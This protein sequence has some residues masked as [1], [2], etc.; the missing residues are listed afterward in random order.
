MKSAI[1]QP[2]SVTASK[3]PISVKS[4][5][6]YYLTEASGTIPSA[7]DSRWKLVNEG[8]AVPMPTSA[9]PY[10]WK[11][12]VTTFTDGTSSTAIE[13]GGSLGKNG[14]DYDLVPSHS[15]IVKAEDG[16][17]S[18]T[19]VSCKIIKRNADG[20]AEQLSSVPTG[21]SIAV[22]R[23]STAVSSAYTPG[24]N[25]S[26]SGTTTSI[27]FVLKY[28]SVEV[29]RHSLNVIAEG[30]QGIDG[31]GIQSQDYRF[32]ATASSAVPSSP[33]NDTTWNTWFT[34]SNSGY[35]AANPYLWR[36]CKTVYVDGNG[37]TET[38]YLVDG[39]TVWGQDGDDAVYLDLDNQ[40]D[41][42]SVNPSG[43]M[44]DH[45]TFTIHATLYKGASPVTGGI[46]APT[47]SAITLNGVTP[48]VNT[49]GGVVTIQYAFTSIPTIFEDR[50][51]TV[52]IPVV[53]GGKTY[54]A[55]FTLAPV[56]KGES[57]RTYNVIPS[58]SAC[59]FARNTDNSLSPASYS[60]TCGYSSSNGS[61]VATYANVTGTF[62]TSWHIFYRTKSNNAYGSWTSY[63]GAITITPSHQAIEF[64]IAKTTTAS[65]VVDSN[66]VDREVVPVLVGGSNGTNAFVVDLD[67]EM[68]AIPC[69][70]SGYLSS[71]RTFNLNIGAYYGTTSVNLNSVSGTVNSTNS[72][73]SINTNT[74]KSPVIT[75]AAGTYAGTYEFT[76]TC[77]HNTYGT[78]TVVFTVAV[79]KAGS[80][81]SSPTMYQ[82]VPSHTALSFAR[83]SNGNL[84]GS[85][86]VTCKIKKTVGASSEVKDS[87]SGLT[88]KW[89]WNSKDPCESAYSPLSLNAGS[90][91]NSNIV[92][93][94]YSGSTRIDRE[95]I[96]IIKDGS[97]GGTG[98]PGNGIASVSFARMFTMAFS[99]PSSSASGWIASTSSSY[100]SE[101]GLSKENRYLWQRKTTTY[102][103][104]SVAT[105]Y[106]VSLLAQYESGVCANLLE[107]TAF[108]DINDMDAWLDK[109]GGVALR[110]FENING[111][112]FA[113]ISNAAY[114][115]VLKQEVYLSTGVKKL[116]ANTWYTFSFYGA[117]YATHEI[118]NS[119]LYQSNNVSPYYQVQNVSGQLYLDANQSIT[120][121]VT[122]YVASSSVYMRYYIYRKNSNGT[123][124]QSAQCHFSSTT[125]STVRMTLTNNSGAAAQYYLGGYV[126]NS[127][128]SQN[129]SSATSHRGYINKVVCYRGCCIDTYLYNA[130]GGSAVVADSSAP[131]ICD[132]VACSGVKSLS[133]AGSYPQMNGTWVQFSGDGHVRWQMNPSTRRHSVTFKTVSTLNAGQSYRILFRATGYAHSGWICMPKLERN[134]MATEWIEH[135]NDRMAAD[136]QHIY[137]GEWSASTAYMYANGVR[138]VVRAP[139][140][141]GTKT[142]FRL[143]KRTPASGRVSSTSPYADTSWWEEA[144]F[145]RFAAAELLLADQAI[146]TFTQTNRILVKNSA[147]SV[148]AGMGGAVGDGDV[149][150]WVGASYENRLSAPFR[151]NIQG[152]IFGTK[153]MIGGWVLADTKMY[154]QLGRISGT[155]STDYTNSSFVPNISLDSVN[156]EILAGKDVRING[157]GIQ[158]FN[159]NTL[160]AK[161]SNEF[162][163]TAIDT[164]PQTGN[165]TLSANYANSV[166]IPTTAYYRSTATWQVTKDCGYCYNGSTI[167]LTNATF[168][169]TLPAAPSGGTLSW[170]TSTLKVYVKGSNGGSYVFY[171]TTVTSSTINQ[172]LTFS[173]TVTIDGTSLKEGRYTIYYEI[174]SQ[175]T[176]QFASGSTPSAT[177][178]VS[179]AGW[180]Y[181]RS[182][183][184]ITLIGNNGIFTRNSNTTY[185]IQTSGG[186]LAR[187]GN[188]A[189]RVTS[190]G[191]QKSVNGGT[192]WTSL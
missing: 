36:C 49:S 2:F 163:S 126:Y 101:S 99:A 175:F 172:T 30:G 100:P 179:A 131:W 79:Q 188:Y 32:K 64:C 3:E 62:N 167:K 77:K 176:S 122:G 128:G 104:T 63:S 117:M 174:V 53:Y 164:T 183:A 85:Y 105:T 92:F 13:F 48:T 84:T 187:C 72:G 61:S 125:V 43:A 14:I 95:T 138:H 123:W 44:T 135:T 181:S 80:P 168:K 82:L 25:V 113:P 41:S 115:D 136:F 17:L 69:D 106:E 142:F 38:T 51:Y 91:A 18:P 148:S 87:Y 98:D 137:A 10:L 31:R 9:A 78:R 12:T 150:L 20:T 96:P 154:S 93:E 133:D 169:I 86:N 16:T 140:S 143:K 60:I 37:N 134:T 83:D 180:S 65:S 76:F 192:N 149:P 55:V 184:L 102:T 151:V 35:S 190:S 15:S 155:E 119:A 68:D 67:N 153:G 34:L 39:P 118:Y 71:A 4:I 22:Y 90:A 46:T 147:G 75:F 189:L 178:Y 27:S 57:A 111:F 81:G 29:E 152:H 33:T 157:D 160:C 144:S 6:R 21:Y 132:G 7:N 74:A 108:N 109:A 170:G 40:M 129:T 141:D 121:D 89:G 159:G 165:G 124:A 66:I 8:E 24:S 50:H 94:L 127:D 173:N 156:G 52:T 114:R 130:S 186:F 19:N 158:L 171:T 185:M 56:R 120:V 177:F 110:T 11:K 73:I 54:S 26:T 47:A 23:D 45:Q 70:S 162:I 5:A 59:P 88:I 112:S 28:G 166:Y 191:I 42:I 146:I 103:K 145:L 1:S 116:E 107:D 182:V 161:L 58:M 97:K 139:K